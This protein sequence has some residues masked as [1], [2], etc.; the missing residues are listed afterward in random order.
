MN[1]L[2]RLIV[3]MILLG[4]YPDD[5]QAAPGDPG[6]PADPNAS[7]AT[8]NLYT[9]LMNL[10]NQSSRRLIS[11]QWGDWNGF[12]ASS[13]ERDAAIYAL[14]GQHVGLWGIFAYKSEP[15]PPP[16]VLGQSVQNMINWWNAGGLIEVSPLIP[17]PE[18]RAYAGADPVA[19]TGNY[20]DLYTNNGNALNTALKGYLDQLATSL[21][22]LQNAGVVVLFRPYHEMN[23]DFF[24]WGSSGSQS[25]F[26]LLW[27]YTF[28]YLT[29]TKGLHNLL[30]VYAPWYKGSAMSMYPGDAYVD[31][32]GIDAYDYQLGGKLSSYDEL[33]ATGKPFALTE[34]GLQGLY[35]GKGVP[36]DLNEAILQIKT[37]MPRT[38][39]FMMWNDKWAIDLQ[40][41]VRAA[42]NDPWAQNRPVPRSTQPPD[43]NLPPGQPDW[44]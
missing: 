43:T 11:G 37:H 26:K 36:E 32:V 6:I 30:Y 31:I 4:L 29:Q 25:Q 7:L 5:A 3:L 23:A 35:G 2:L 10:P 9:Y 1:T 38:V 41:N 28:T 16:Y 12:N 34:F 13:L 15:L 22:A 24:W 44:W 14:S 39:Y 21:S 42:F 17:N 27:Q 19:L 8:R 40:S 18:T 33:V 20:A